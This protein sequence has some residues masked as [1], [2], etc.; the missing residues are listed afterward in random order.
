MNGAGKMWLE[1]RKCGDGIF[2]DVVGSEDVASE[3]R[4]YFGL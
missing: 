3:S 1:N 4:Q 2:K